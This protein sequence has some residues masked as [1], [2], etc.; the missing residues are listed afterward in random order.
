MFFVSHHLFSQTN[1][2]K[3]LTYT[4]EEVQQLQ[5]SNEKPVVVF[6]HTA[7]CKFCFAMKEKTFT[8][9][10]VIKLLNE[11]FYFISLDA[12]FKM[13]INYMGH[14][15]KYRKTTSSS[16][17]HE[18]AEI[19]ATTEKGISYPTT[20]I[21]DSNRTIDEQIDY[22]LSD[23]QLVKGLKRYLQK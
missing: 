4:F 3:L 5:K 11:K 8:N 18:L 20:V 15:F 23:N 19:L 9:L 13:P 10:N 12:E 1:D 7:W 22:Y 16:G 14:E 6:I 17:I 2:V 21:L